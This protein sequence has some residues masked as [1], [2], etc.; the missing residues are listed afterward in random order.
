MHIAL[1]RCHHHP[2]LGRRAGSL[3]LGFDERQKMRHC[4]L[5]DP[6]GLHDLRQKHLP[7]SEQVAHPIHAVHQRAFNDGQGFIATRLGQLT[8]LLGI[9]N[10][11]L[12]DPFDQR[13]CQPLAD[14]LLAPG[15]IHYLFPGRP[16]DGLGKLH[17]SLACLR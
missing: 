4:L 7:R 16:L 14:R 8:R 9:L 2:A 10:H 5:H 13:M 12:G 3:L 1:H 17:E 6:C 15:Q 11:K